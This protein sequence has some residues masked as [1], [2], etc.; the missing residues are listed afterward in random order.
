[1][2][3]T[4]GPIIA[5]LAAALALVAAVVAGLTLAP[6]PS[7]VVVVGSPGPVGQPGAVGPTGDP[8][9]PGPAGAAGES[10][11]TGA[12]GATG[13]AGPSGATGAAGPAGAPGPTGGIGPAATGGVSV[14]QVTGAPILSPETPPMRLAAGN[15]RI[16]VYVIAEVDSPSAERVECSL[17]VIPDNGVDFGVTLVDDDQGADSVMPHSASVII[18]GLDPMDVTVAC[19]QNPPQT[20]YLSIIVSASSVD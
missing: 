8:G 4:A 15:W 6:P 14:A 9:S 13:P 2:R 12:R 16:D 3:S 11:P 20:T 7:D 1:M 10:G 5:A 18:G 17:L 19:V